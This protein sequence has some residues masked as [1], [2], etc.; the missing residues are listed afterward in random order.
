MVTGSDEESRD[1]PFLW[2]ELPGS[3]TWSGDNKEKQQQAAIQRCSE[4]RM[5]VK[6]GWNDKGGGNHH[7]HHHDSNG[8]LTTGTEL[9]FFL[10]AY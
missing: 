7:Q 1:G 4:G 2:K 3:S 9:D 8:V 10:V 5:R 6:R